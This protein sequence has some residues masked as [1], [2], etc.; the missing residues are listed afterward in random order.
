MPDPTQFFCWFFF[1]QKLPGGRRLPRED[2]RLLRAQA[3]L[4]RRL[5]LRAG[6]RKAA[7]AT[8]QMGAMGSLHHGKERTMRSVVQQ[9]GASEYSRVSISVLTSSSGTEQDQCRGEV[10]G[11]N[12]L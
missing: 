11:H 2:Q 1:L 10:A 7:A 12:D 3:L 4:R 6:G 8:S 5:P 9:S